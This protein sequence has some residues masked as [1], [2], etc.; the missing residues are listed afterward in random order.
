MCCAIQNK[1]SK[2]RKLILGNAILAFKSF[3]RFSSLTYTVWGRM[4]KKLFEI[5]IQKENYIKLSRIKFKDLSIY[6]SIYL[7]IFHDFNDH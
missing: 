1:K 6:L 4:M 5:E 7:S 3:E 2:F